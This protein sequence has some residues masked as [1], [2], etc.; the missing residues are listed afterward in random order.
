MN[1]ESN[2]GLNTRHRILLLTLVI[3]PIIGWLGVLDNFSTQYL[4][5][6]LAGA[7]LI[8]G[9]ARGINALVSLL[10]G[11]ELNLLVMTF[12]IGEVLDPLNDL[13]ERFSEVVMFALGS[14]ALQAI[15]LKLVSHT[16]FNV[17]LTLL[18]MGTGVALLINNKAYYQF[19]LRCFLIAAFFRFS[20]GLVVVANG[21]VDIAFLNSDDNIRH[22]EMAQFQGELREINSMATAS[23]NSADLIEQTEYQIAGKEA[24]QSEIGDSILTLKTELSQAE[25][26]LS[27]LKQESTLCAILV[28]SKT[29]S[30]AVLA[31][32]AEVDRLAGIENELESSMQSVQAEI[33]AMRYSIECMKKQSR[34]ESCS[35][36]QALKDTVST[37]DL[38]EKLGHVEG[39][40]GAFAD[41]T[42][43]LLMSLLLKSVIIPLIFFYLLLK[44]VRSSWSKL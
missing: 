8:Y 32:K 13:I 25:A 18:A 27:E 35:V 39:R 10:Q 12:S 11:T 2:I 22:Q 23:V 9:T 16:V 40:M 29:C 42:I 6:S 21:W 20:L 30:P 34:G 33:D 37:E 41:N 14:L 5:D 24:E 38:R 36:L 7:G 19:L 43:N 1:N 15:L 44:V 3:L 28:T 4:K 26:T 31:A 17:L